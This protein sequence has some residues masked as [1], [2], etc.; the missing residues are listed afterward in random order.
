MQD[1]ES[2][3]KLAQAM[4][5]IG[6]LSDKETVC[7]LTNMDEP[8]GKTV[9]NILEVKEAVLFLQGDMEQDVKEVVLELGAQM[10]KLDGKNAN[11]EENKKMILDVIESGKA[12]EK[13]LELVENQCGDI[14]YIKDLSKFKKAKNIYEVKANKEGYVQKLNAKEIG[15]V[16]R[17]LGAGRIRKEDS[18]DYEAGIVLNKKIGNKVNVG[19]VLAEI[20][21][22]KEEI[23]KE[24]EK[25]ILNA[26]EIEDNPIEDNPIEDKI[27]ILG[28]ME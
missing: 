12:Y 1:L 21:T 5:N 7:V 23:I 24:A 13:F 3:K 10:I 22:N 20:H 8:L 15:E 11:I 19:E 25:R 26:Y 9:G 6:K 2:A 27:N 17:D 16:A 28:V 4:I 18:I 14:S